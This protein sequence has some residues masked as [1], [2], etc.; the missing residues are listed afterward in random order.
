MQA[1]EGKSPGTTE[2]TEINCCGSM[3]FPYQT[4]REANN[5][6]CHVGV[7]G[8]GIY[9]L[10]NLNVCIFM[11]NHQKVVEICQSESKWD[12]TTDTPGM[13]NNIKACHPSAVHHTVR[14]P[15][16]SYRYITSVSKSI[17]LKRAEVFL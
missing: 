8:R 12:Q 7:A 5:V 4:S 2:V 17:H 15:C 10:G 16:F 11:T 14:L 9:P 3:M 1:Q 13:A 6:K